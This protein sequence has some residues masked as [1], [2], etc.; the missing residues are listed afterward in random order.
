[1]QQEIAK[2]AA[3]GVPAAEMQRVKTKMRSDFY[4]AIELPIN[5][6]DALA[7][8]ELLLGGADALN[9]IPAQVE[10]V[11]SQ[12]LQRV[13]AKYLTVPNRTVVDIRAAAGAKG[14]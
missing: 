11:T 12:D 6:A 8:A 7:L 10:A 1:V 3:Q 2:V 5:R 9:E 13:A 4:S 14:E